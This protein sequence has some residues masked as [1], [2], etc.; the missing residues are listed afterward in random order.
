M[1]IQDTDDLQY[2][3]PQPPGI[4]ERWL[5]KIFVEDLKTKLLALSITLVLWFAVTGQRKP[6]TKRITGVQLGFIHADDMAISNDPPS[7]VDITLTGSNDELAQINPLELL[8]T[9]VVGDHATG[10][11]VIRLSRDRVKLEL[12]EGVSMI[13]FQ[14]AIVTVRLEP[15]VERQVEVTLKFEGNLP[16][17]YEVYSAVANPAKVRVRGP[18]GI[19]NGI[20]QAATE[21]ILLDAKTSSF[22]LNQVA[23]DVPDQ[24]VDIPDGLV[25]VHVEIGERA[26]VK[27]FDD[28]PV[29]S[30]AGVK[31]R[32]SAANL[33]LSA[34]AWVFTQLRSDQ[35]HLVVADGAGEF[36]P[37]SRNSF[38]LELPPALH[39]KVRI[40]SIKPSKFLPASK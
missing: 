2:E 15:I 28:V 27:T 30:P 22:D 7:R 17:G 24:K 25:Q 34:P 12:P 35:I 40:V 26:V 10:D 13:G 23:V 31:L 1:P 3:P 5:R 39:G 9:V 21:S 11:R 38:T 14:P 18:A 6:M 16:E 37:E 8:A 4:L 32:P 29:Q 33:I 20:K 19:V 36:T